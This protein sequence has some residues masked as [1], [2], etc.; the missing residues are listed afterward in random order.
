MQQGVA[1][2][3]REKKKN[4]ISARKYTVII[5]YFTILF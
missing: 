1:S 4:E 3:F 2:I 5:Q